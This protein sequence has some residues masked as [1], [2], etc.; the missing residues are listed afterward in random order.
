M[1][2]RKPRPT[3]KTWWTKFR[4]GGRAVEIDTSEADKR[5]AQR[6]EDQ[7][8]AEMKVAHKAG[9]RVVIAEAPAAAPALT[10]G[11]AVSEYIERV[12]SLH[13]SQMHRCNT[14]WSLE[15]LVR[16][17]G[18]ESPLFQIDNRL[19][20]DVVARRR[21]ERG[22]HGQLLSKTTINRSVTEPLRKV[23]RHAARLNELSLKIDWNLHLLDEPEEIVRELQT[24]EEERLFAADAMR[25]D[26]KP[27]LRIALLLGLRAGEILRM[28]WADVD[29][30]NRR[31]KVYAKRKTRFVPIIPEVREVLF[32]LQAHHP[33]FVFTYEAKRSRDGRKRGERLPLTVSGF[34]TAWR[35]IRA[36]AGIENFRR[37]DLR[38]TTGTRVMRQSR[39][40]KTVQRLLGHNQIETTMR[41]AHVYDEDVFEA[42]AAAAAQNGERNGGRAGG[43]REETQAAQGLG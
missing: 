28:T 29:F 38:H 3:S 19:V 11:A 14:G 24:G 10:F 34:N 37:H 17:I 33:H 42:V 32:P 22:R 31:I 8:K 9:K 39:N 18:A 13:E 40:P 23:L 41:Y 2:V 7:L 5:A 26:Y 15:W 21:G 35:R 25:A 30:G 36:K 27:A 16:E 1:A 6:V 20:S 12:V 4:V 43:E